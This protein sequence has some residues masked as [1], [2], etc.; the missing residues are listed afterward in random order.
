MRFSPMHDFT[1][2]LLKG[3]YASSVCA[4]LDMLQAAAVLAPRA[5]VAPPRWRVVSVEAPTVVLQGGVS[6]EATVIK[7][8]PRADR[9][10]WI[11][12]GLGLSRPGD[13]AVRLLQEDAQRA[14]RLI[15]Q[16]AQRGGQVAASCSAVF[17]LQHAG[18]L[19]GRKATTSW[20]L[21]PA[22]HQIDPE[23][24]VD[25]NRIVCAD[26]AVVTAGAAFAQTD[27]M[28]HLLRTRCGSALTEAVSRFLLIGA[29]EAQAPFV[30]PDAF[31]S[32]DDLMARLAAHIER[33]LPTPPDMPELASAFCLSG[34]TLARRVRQATGQSTLA[35]VQSV[36]LHRA[37]ALLASSRMTV[38]QVAAAVGY[39]DATALRRMMRKV[40]GANPSQFRQVGVAG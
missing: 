2:L 30:V 29:R 33:A 25:A 21:A 27:L 6:V 23:C 15:R 39:R 17:L 31:A 28:L 5:A 38:E 12:P 10:T 40:A 14:I 19:S 4:T 7:R 3:A 37:Q 1:V 35:L 34:R 18:L 32:G 26:G 16:H 13:M 20:W 11:V 36:R 24:R 8:L 22:L 9:S